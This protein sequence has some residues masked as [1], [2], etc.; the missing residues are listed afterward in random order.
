MW[1]GKITID[2]KKINEIS[3]VCLD[4]SHKDKTFSYTFQGDDLVIHHFDRNQCYKKVLWLINKVKALDGCKFRV[5]KY[6]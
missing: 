3:K 6:E 4:I 5:V 1:D 2:P